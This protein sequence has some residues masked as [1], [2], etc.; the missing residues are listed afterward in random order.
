MS[1]HQHL[2][3]LTD[4]YGSGRAEDAAPP[5][6][7]S[8]LIRV[9]LQPCESTQ[10]TKTHSLSACWGRERFEPPRLPYFGISADIPGAVSVVSLTL[11]Q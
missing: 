6:S 4:G 11:T 3:Q 7:S 9:V 1:R 2:T 8:P 5:L 10:H